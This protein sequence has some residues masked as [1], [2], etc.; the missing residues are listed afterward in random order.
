[1]SDP[2]VLAWAERPYHLRYMFGELR[3]GSKAFQALALKTHFLKVEHTPEQLIAGIGSVGRDVDVVVMGSIPV[4]SAYPK[5]SKVAGWLLYVPAHYPRYYV[6]LTTTFETYLSNFSAKTRSTLRR[7]V[8]KFQEFSGGTLDFR[9]YNSATAFEEFYPLALKLSQRT[10]QHRLL[11]A[12][13]PAS[14]SFLSSARALA[15]VDH[16]RAYLLFHD[17]KPVAYLYCPLADGVLTYAHLGY[18]A[19][20]AEWSCGTVLQYLAFERLFD[21]ESCQIFDFTEGEGEHKKL[22]AT[23]MK[24]CAQVL[25]FRPKLRNVVLVTSHAAVAAASSGTV[26]LLDHLG[27]KRR[28]KKL[29]RRG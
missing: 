19:D 14:D 25:C 3:L 26:R 4:P 20:F 1:M 15:A 18:D 16:V 5:L 10:Y 27:L 2:A 7:K 17:Q 21:D 29:L 12:G 9:E 28:M 23:G 22:F 6:D 11:E 13:L 24:F 8:R